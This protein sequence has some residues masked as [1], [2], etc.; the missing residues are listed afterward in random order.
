MVDLSGDSQ[1]VLAII[2]HITFFYQTDV[3]LLVIDIMIITLI[4]NHPWGSLTLMS[5][6]KYQKVGTGTAQLNQ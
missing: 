6:G 4:G 3:W 5:V 2:E 1:S